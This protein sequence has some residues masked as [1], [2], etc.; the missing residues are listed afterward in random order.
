M[1]SSKKKTFS[2]CI[3]LHTLV[4]SEQQPLV[5][6]GVYNNTRYDAYAQE[7][8]PT[9]DY[10]QHAVDWENESNAWQ[11]TL[12]SIST[13]LQDQQDNTNTASTPQA[14]SLQPE[15]PN[16]IQT[17]C[18]NTF[19]Q[20]I[21]DIYKNWIHCR[22]YKQKFTFSAQDDAWEYSWTRR[23]GIPLAYFEAWW[24]A[25]RTVPYTGDADV[26]L[27][28]DPNNFDGSKLMHMVAAKRRTNFCTAFRRNDCFCRASIVCILRLRSW[29]WSLMHNL[30]LKIWERVFVSVPHDDCRVTKFV[31]LPQ[32]S[33]ELLY[34]GND[35]HV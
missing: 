16:R 2:V 34:L 15:D 17:K 33:A 22:W 4:I 8:P 3:S 35:F 20:S 28:M 10:N 1:P 13:P 27:I 11:D 5:T 26:R 23:T 29:T 25:L 21:L 14:D 30:S 19:C 18:C 7:G 31:C 12:T 32:P 6:G 24:E 9:Y